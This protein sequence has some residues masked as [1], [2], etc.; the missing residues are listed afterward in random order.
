MEAQQI[1]GQPAREAAAAHVR[2]EEEPQP[3]QFPGDF[4]GGAHGTSASETRQRKPVFLNRKHSRQRQRRVHAPPAAVAAQLGGHLHHGQTVVWIGQT[5]AGGLVEEPLHAIDDR[6]LNIREVVDVAPMPGVKQQFQLHASGFG[7]ARCE[8]GGEKPDLRYRRTRSKPKS[9]IRG[10]SAA[11]PGDEPPG[12]RDNSQVNSKVIARR[13][14]FRHRP[15]TRPGGWKPVRGRHQRHKPLIENG[16]LGTE[17][18]DRVRRHPPP[19][20][21]AVEIGEVRVRDSR[22]GDGQRRLRP[23]GQRGRQVD[24]QQTVFVLEVQP[25]PIETQRPNAQAGI[26]AEHERA[27]PAGR[28]CEPQRDIEF[29]PFAGMDD[30]AA[31]DMLDIREAA[32]QRRRFPVGGQPLLAPREVRRRVR[33]H[34]AEAG[35][36]KREQHDAAKP[37]PQSALGQAGMASRRDQRRRPSKQDQ[38]SALREKHGV[39]RHGRNVRNGTAVA[40]HGRERRQQVDGRARQGPRPEAEKREGDRKPHARVRQHS[41]Q[42]RDG[43]RPEQQRRRRVNE[44]KRDGRRRRGRLARPRQATG[45][46]AVNRP[47]RKRHQQPANHGHGRHPSAHQRNSGKRFGVQHGRHAIALV[48][49]S[50]RHAKQRDR[51]QRWPQQVDADLREKKP[52]R[53]AA[54]ERH[55]P[56]QCAVNVGVVREHRGRDGE[57]KRH[58]EPHPHR[59]AGRAQFRMDDGEG[60]ATAQHPR[61][62]VPFGC[63]PAPPA[64]RRPC[65]GWRGPSPPPSPPRPRWRT[66]RLAAVR[67]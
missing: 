45:G 65:R 13:L 53:H 51:N 9:H 29:Q 8:R 16:C 17:G 46:E 5:E 38:R 36:A 43:R 58:A 19:V 14:C 10:M 34:G 48:A 49:S 52:R 37:I 41:R 57:R 4:F 42:Q 67:A 44:Q 27:D 55:R 32:R 15:N 33:R 64:T 12:R 35:G 25:P 50:L 18:V 31:F 21:E 60:L 40:G 11:G 61:L 28:R 63:S 22:R 62:L 59:P 1:A 30:N 54:N 56:G 2:G 39:E 66:H 26:E 6:G 23:G 3:R 47:D 24:G 20:D 7:D